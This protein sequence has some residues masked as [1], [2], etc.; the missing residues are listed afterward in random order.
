VRTCSP[1]PLLARLWRVSGYFTLLE[2]HSFLRGRKCLALGEDFVISYL[3]SG[4]VFGSEIFI[5]SF[6]T[7]S[8]SFTT[9]AIEIAYT[10][11]KKAMPQKA[12]LLLFISTLMSWSLL[13]QVSDSI[14]TNAERMP[15]FPGCTAYKVGTDDRR[16]CSNQSVKAFIFN[17]IIY[18]QT[19]KEEN[20]EGAVYVRFIVDEMGYVQQPKLLKD[21]GGG[22]GAAA[23][24]VLKDM[25]K[26]EPAYH[27]G[28]RVK[29]ALDL[30]IHFYFKENNSPINQAYTL[31][32]GKM[33]EYEVSR[34][35]LRRNL[36]E[37]ITIFNEDGSNMTISDL[38][39]SYTKNNKLIQKSSS[40]K[41]TN[42]MEKMVKKLKKGGLFSIIA[43]VQKEGKFIEVAKEFKVI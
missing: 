11:N 5:L 25:P 36:N 10:R 26:W 9:Q 35:N 28:R 33:N 1:Q 16:A 21:I 4:K 24:S 40:G 37:S 2:A 27:Q 41:I 43:T 42:D 8:S 14:Y 30:P 20:I 3:P 7:A 15:Y 31:I 6:E 39:F 22:C 12:I 34:K 18:P 32:W 17:H 38:R 29:V 23:L 13:G 19:A